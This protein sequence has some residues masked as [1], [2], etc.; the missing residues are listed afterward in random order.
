MMC[1]VLRKKKTGC[2][3]LSV[4]DHAQ[5]GNIKVVF[6]LPNCISWKQ[7][8]D[9]GIIAALKKRYKYLYLEDVLKFYELHN[10][11]KAHKIEQAKRL[12]RGAVGVA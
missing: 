9:M 1:S 6:F 11:L 12:P 7:L 3:I 4:L 5:I 10:K 8:C 2:P